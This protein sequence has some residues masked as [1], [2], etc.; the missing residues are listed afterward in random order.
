MI[1]TE[2]FSPAALGLDSEHGHLR[3]LDGF[4]VLILEAALVALTLVA[5]AVFEL[6]VRA[7]DRL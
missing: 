6:Y 1:R 2:A 3:A 4:I 5:F 7:C